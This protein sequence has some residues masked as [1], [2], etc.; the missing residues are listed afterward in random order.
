MNTSTK[1]LLLLLMFFVPLMGNT[2]NV[3]NK[4]FDEGNAA[5]HTANAL[6]YSNQYYFTQKSF[7]SGNAVL[8]ALIL[9]TIGQL[10][11]KKSLVID[12]NY[13]IFYGYAGSLQRLTNN[14]FCQQYHIALDSTIN[15]LFFDASLNVI[16][17][18]HYNLGNYVNAGIIKQINDSTLLML[19]RVKN[20]T[21]Y[22]LFLINTDLQGN[23]RWRT[24]FGEIDKDD[25]GFAI[26]HIN[27]KILVSGQ[28]YYTGQI[29][30]PHI[31]EFNNSGQLLFDTTYTQFDNGGTIIYH[32]NFGLYLYSS[33][34][35]YPTSMYPI[36]LKINNDY[37]IHWSNEYFKNEKLVSSGAMTI[38][39][40]GIIS[41]AGNKMVNN[42]T[43]GLFFQINSNGDSLK[44][45]LIEHIPG[46]TAYLHNIRPTSDGG[47]ILAGQTNTTSQ[48]SWIVKVNSWGCDELPC[49]V[50]VL[51]QSKNEDGNLNCY[52]N[53]SNGLGTIKG[54]F[55]NANSTNR[56]KVFN[57]LGQLVFSKT[58]AAKEFEM[59]VN[60]PSSGLYLVVLYQKNVPVQNQKWMVK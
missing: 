37:T 18:T 35:N 21:K 28:T 38:N 14:E 43:T 58:I 19:G 45:K 4:A 15:L 12:S 24:T 44:T 55:E 29:A 36:I 34:N 2:Q 6:E 23:E 40:D 52:P 60:L 53:P 51:E 42:V 17:N 59:E 33:F 50:S 7:I 41:L 22:N 46:K 56:I 9:D 10:L 32:E 30:H 11:Q 57:S 48:D 39:N 8:E 25:Y 1:H 16:R 3:F 13:N 27:N 26:E 31:F 47:Y 54:S 49:T 20:T 5:N